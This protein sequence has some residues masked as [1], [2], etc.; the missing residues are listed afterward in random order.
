MDF[1]TLPLIR[2]KFHSFPVIEPRFILQTEFNPPGFL[3]C[4]F[5]I[6]NMCLK[7]YGIYTGPGSSINKRMC[8]TEASIV[9]LCYLRNNQAFISFKKILYC[10]HSISFLSVSGYI[11]KN[12]F[13]PSEIH[14]PGKKNDKCNQNTRKNHHPGHLDRIADQAGPET[15]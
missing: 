3:G 9:S 12:F 2:S 1:K 10:L 14:C 5:S 13:H 6:C 15:F 8:H 7:F 4:A 11:R